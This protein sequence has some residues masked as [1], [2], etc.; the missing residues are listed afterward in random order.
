MN[1]FYF[2]F[3]RFG[4]GVVAIMTGW[5]IRALQVPLVAPYKALGKFPKALYGT[6][7]GTCSA[8]FFLPVMLWIVCTAKSENMIQE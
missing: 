1:I 4:L 7:G 2:G 5:K 3:I 6:M 8:R